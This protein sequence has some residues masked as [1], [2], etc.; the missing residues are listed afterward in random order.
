MDN[1]DKMHKHDRVGQ[2]LYNKNNVEQLDS[3]KSTH[4]VL[5]IYFILILLL[6]G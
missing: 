1:K 2:F 6:F 5:H 3:Q 4:Y